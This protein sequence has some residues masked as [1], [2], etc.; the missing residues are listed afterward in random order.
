MKVE[1]D[2]S[3]IVPFLLQKNILQFHGRKFTYRVDRLQLPHGVEG[4]YEYIQHP[5]AG[6]A[7]PVTADGKFILV[8]Q[9]RFPIQRYLLE[10]PAGTLEADESPDLTIKR[11]LEEETGYRGNRWDKLGSFYICPGY[12]DEV[13]HA[14]LARDLQKLENPPAQDD[15]EE[16][17]VMILDRQEVEAIILSGKAET[18]LDHRARILGQF[19][20]LR[21]H[22]WADC[23]GIFSVPIAP[24]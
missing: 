5:G 13:I 22:V 6:L 19:W 16:I 15:D 17:E 14:Y 21:G 18:S 7:V 8:K 11:E 9:Y 1:T 24:G 20:T 12:T 23:G 4:E 10:F 3:G 2:S